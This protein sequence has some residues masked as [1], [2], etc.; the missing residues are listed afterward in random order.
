[1]LGNVWEW[2][3]DWHDKYPEEDREDWRGPVGGSNRVLRGG[4]W[5]IVDWF[6]RAD[7][8]LWAFHPA[9]R[10][11]DLGFRLVRAL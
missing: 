5:D 8:R 2:C 3:W 7:Y 10:V 11:I 1:M 6:C 4:S 9:Y